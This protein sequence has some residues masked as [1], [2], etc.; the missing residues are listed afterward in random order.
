MTKTIIPAPVRYAVT[1]KASQSKAFQ[2][3]TAGF[4]KWWKRTGSGIGNSTLR[5]AIVEPFAGGRWY[6]IVE[7][8]VE[9]DW[10]KYWRGSRTLDCCWPGNRLEVSFRSRDR[11]RNPL[12]AGG[13]GRHSRRT[14]TSL[15]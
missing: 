10:E 7:D 8:Y 4:G 5:T 12:S 2:T 6:E 9:T 3:L 13:A 14:R 15:S 1:V 11:S